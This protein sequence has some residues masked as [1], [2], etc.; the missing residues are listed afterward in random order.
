[1]VMK[2]E[3]IG[4]LAGFFSI[5]GLIPQVYKSYKTQHTRDL[6]LKWLILSV[7]AHILWFIYGVSNMLMP[8]MMTS[9]SVMVLTLAL[10]IM[11]TRKKGK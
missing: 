10:L 5:V 6:S 1:M 4:L 8:V 11:K 9:S 7:V 3:F 2:L